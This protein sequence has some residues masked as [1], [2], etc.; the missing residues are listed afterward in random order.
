HCLELRDRPSELYAIE[1]VLDRLFEDSLQSAGHL[2]QPHRRPKADEHVLI[3]RHRPHG[4]GYDGVERDVIAR[5]AGKT[6]PLTDR[7]AGRLDEC[8]RRFVFT[9]GENREMAGVASE[10]HAARPTL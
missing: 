8:H 7:Q 5:L 2:L 1:R 9:M 3:D 6:G 4:L 10:W